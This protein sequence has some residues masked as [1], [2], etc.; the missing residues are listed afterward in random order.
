MISAQM[1][2]E[3][4]ERTGAGMMDCKKALTETDGDMEKAVDFLR[5][6]GLAA[7]EKKAG[8]IAAEGMVAA[9]LS[10]DAK[11]GV[12]VEVNCETDFVAKNEDFKGFAA[13]V[14]QQVLAGN[15]ADVEALLGEALLSDS[16]KTVKDE[17]TEKVAVIGE[18]INIRRFEKVDAAD[19]CVAAYI[20]GGGKL[21]VVVY[22]K[23][24]VVNDEI[25]AALRNIAMQIAAMDPKYV[26]RD[27]VPADFL[28]HEKEILM[29]Q[30]KEENPNKPD[31]IIEKMIVGRLN[32]EMKEI[33]LL[34]QSYVQDGDLTVA[35]YAAKVGKENN[36][37]LSVVRF[38]RFKTGEGLEKK[39]DDFA[40]EVENMFK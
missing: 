2:K 23:T 13:D 18:N 3:L 10:A 40:C 12:L 9:A 24:D 35:Q 16:S 28:A 36:A 21:G 37:D 8:R 39:Q 34:D 33:C 17:L 14:A 27:E 30:A 32:K 25:K 15:A 7:A 22:G 11:Q 20:H 6:K 38:V 1:V 29:A 31:N 26:S 19:G 5:E 4:R